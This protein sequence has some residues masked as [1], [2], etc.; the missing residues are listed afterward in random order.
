[1]SASASRLRLHCPCLAQAAAGGA[2]SSGTT[3]FHALRPPAISIHDCACRKPRAKLLV[4]AAA[5]ARPR[6]ALRHAAPLP[7]A[8]TPFAPPVRPAPADC[9]RI[10]K[11]AS[12]SPECF[13][14]ALVYIDR[15]IQRNALLL[16]S[17]NVHRI[18]ITAVSA[19]R[20]ARRRQDAARRYVLPTARAA[21]PPR[22]SLSLS[23]TLSLSRR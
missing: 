19:A 11:Y 12:C 21:A 10:L 6:R 2:P 15:L 4:A 13:V 7:P 8:L 22:V 20:E 9:S 3:K 16:T 1:V 18:I 5:G 23:L 17:L 14:L